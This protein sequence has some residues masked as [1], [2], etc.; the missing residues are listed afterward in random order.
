MIFIAE[1]CQNHN[2]DLNILEEMV[3]RA[4]EN[5]ATYCKIQNIFAED[6]TFRHRFEEGLI[7][8]NN[9]KVIKRP[10][11]S[12]YDRLKKLELDYKTQEK[13]IEICKKNNVKALTTCF[14]VHRAK[15]L[16]NLDWDV[17]K[18]AS[19][20]CGSL[21]LVKKLSELFSELIISTGASYDKEIEDTANY[22]NS[23]NH[24]FSFLHCVTIYPTPLNNLN[25][26]RLKFLSKFTDEIGY[27]DHSLVKNDN[28]LASKCAIY[29]G[30]KLIER[31]FTILNEDQTKDGPVSINPSQLKELV[32]FSDLD[33]NDQFKYLNSELNEWEKVV[34]GKINRK[35]TD[36]ELLNRDYYRGRFAEKISENKYNY[37]W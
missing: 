25:L 17:I 6:L 10:Y 22:L 29:L 35:L 3:V 7:E 34:M 2:G 4:S 26:S 16:S 19:Y 14:T 36:V 1:L 15:E 30:A 31:H 18:V 13:F 28:L 24:K 21:K 33:K 20:D 5:G 37:N 12:E 11:G 8:K 9:V 23:I 27:S 32:Y